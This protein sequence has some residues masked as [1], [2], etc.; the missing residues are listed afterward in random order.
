M[1]GSFQTGKLDDFVDVLRSVVATIYVDSPDWPVAGLGITQ[2]DGL[3]RF[4]RLQQE[5]PIQHAIAMHELLSTIPGKGVCSSQAAISAHFAKQ[6]WTC[7]SWHS[8]RNV[9]AYLKTYACYVQHDKIFK[10]VPRLLLFYGTKAL[11]ESPAKFESIVT[12][13][14]D[15]V[16]MLGDFLVIAGIGL[17]PRTL[18]ASKFANAAAKGQP[19][20][21]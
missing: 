13:L 2:A 3:K 4:E 11:H 17:K 10:R 7:P 8:Q 6:E 12:A 19:D 1:L 16:E 15:D 5:T 9:S 20:R 21:G 14:Q 18:G